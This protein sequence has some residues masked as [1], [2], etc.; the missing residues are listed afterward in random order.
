MRKGYNVSMFSVLQQVERALPQILE[1]KWVS[2]DKDGLRCIVDD[3]VVELFRTNEEKKFTHNPVIKVVA[4]CCKL[5]LECQKSFNKID[6]MCESGF[7]FCANDAN[8]H[9]KILPN[10]DDVL[11]LSVF[12][13]D[14][15]YK[16]GSECIQAA[17]ILD[18]FKMFYPSPNNRVVTNK[19]PT[20]LWR[21]GHDI[22]GRSVLV[23]FAQTI[24]WLA[25]SPEEAEK[26]A[27]ALLHHAR[28]ARG[29]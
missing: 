15:L 3:Y 13:K 24:K 28:K 18:E 5:E 12:H 27:S 7:D 29:F 6:F 23:D 17:V 20:Y 21:V 11:I 4:G 2:C 9:V 19:I 10:N 22:P 25:L 16:Q 26:A 1:E 14:N 8:T